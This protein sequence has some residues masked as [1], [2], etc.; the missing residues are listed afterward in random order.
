MNVAGMV[1]DGLNAP[2]TGPLLSDMTATANGVGEGRSH[3]TEKEIQDMEL[4]LRAGMVGYAYLYPHGEEIPKV[5]VFCMTP[6]NIANFIGQHRADCSEMTLTDRLDMTVLTTYGEFIDKCPNQELLRE[7]LQHLMPIQ[8]GEAVPKEVTA[9]TMDTYDLYDDLLEEVLTG[10]TPED[11]KQAELSAKS[12]VW[13]YY[14]PG[15]DVSA[16]P[17]LEAKWI[18]EKNLRSYKLENTPENL[19]AFIQQK[20]DVEEIS[21]RDPNGAEVIIARQGYVHMCLD[22]AYL[23]NQL[24]PALAELRRSGDVP[25]IQ[26]AGT[27]VQ[28]DMKMEM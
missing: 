22:E 21:F 16:Y 3:L 5:Y 11:L 14:K 7:V 27:P 23:K 10:M 2:F 1:S 24:Q 25:V 19:A 17:Y 20:K 9:V 12:T 6:E 13:H 18:G 4:I 15:V 26:E 8:M 28:S